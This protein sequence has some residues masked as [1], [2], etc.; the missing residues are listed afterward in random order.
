MYL[1]NVYVKIPKCGLGVK[2]I[3]SE[4]MN[5]R[6]QVHLIHMNSEPHEGY[7]FIMNYQDHLTKFTIPRSLIPKPAD[8]IAYQL[9]VYI[10]FA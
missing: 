5:S 4:C 3:L 2:P 1:N 6:S 9:F 8:E 10:L 7:R